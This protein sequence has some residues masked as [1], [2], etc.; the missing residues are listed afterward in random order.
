MKYNTRKTIFY[1]WKETAKYK[2]IFIFLLISVIASSIL[3]SI[4]PVYLKKF[5]NI[6]TNNSNNKDVVVKSLVSVIVLV[7]IFKVS[8]WFISRLSD[9]VLSFLESKIMIDL[10]NLCFVCVHK[11]SFSYFSNTF[12]GSIVKKVK[13]FVSSFE[14][15][16]DQL[17]YDILPSLVKVVVITLVLININLFLGLGMLIGIFVFVF[18]NFIFVR[19]KLKFDMAKTEAET[20]TSSVLADTVTNNINIKLFNGYKIENKNFFEKTEKLRR[21]IKKAWNIDVFFLAIQSLLLI[22]L[23]IVMYFLAVNLWK[24]NSISIG[25]FVLIQSYIMMIFQIVWNFGRTLKRVYESLSNS[26]EMS[27][28]LETQYEVV[29]IKNASNLRITKGKIEFKDVCFSY[30]EDGNIVDNFN[31]QINPKETVAIIGFSG[32]GKT[33][34]TK[35]LL[36]FFDIQKG[37]I[38]IDGQNISEVT[39]ESLRRNVSL[40][41][42][43]PILFHRSLIENIRY[44]RQDATDEEILMAS[45]LSHCDEFISKLKYGYNTFVGERGIKLS[46]G[47][48]QR[49]SIARAILKNAPILILDEATS[50][51][52]SESEKLIQDSLDKLMKDKTVIVI[53]HRL[54]TIKKVDR[55]VVIDDKTV[56]EDGTHINLI[57]FKR[58]LY[59]KLWDIQVGG[60]FK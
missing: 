5:F 36:R 21:L 12:T 17:F 26:Q 48:R 40:V 34:L 7:M 27:V 29:D 4:I 49:V 59:K 46:G 3:D 45:K 53:A 1:Y 25:D 13:G 10:Y 18:I 11:H 2:F 52:D 47:E 8:R 58:G 43:D 38:L 39:Q 42:Q 15:L 41:P 31:L 14:N 24:K 19:Y 44:G 56:G 51:L 37:K 33:T 20:V 16:F 22:V 30:E 55:F 60:F 57:K 28:I 50:S 35:L 6:L 23:E 54:S 32:S 9:F